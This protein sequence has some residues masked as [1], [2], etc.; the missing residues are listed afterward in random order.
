MKSLVDWP[1]LPELG[2]GRGVM[3]GGSTADRLLT[4]GQ[5]HTG[6]PVPS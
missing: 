2:R 1:L 6:H 3:Y 4:K 5:W